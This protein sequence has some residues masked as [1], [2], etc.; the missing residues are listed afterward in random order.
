M[1]KIYVIG[2]GM[3]PWNVPEQVKSLIY[4]SDL[5]V[6][7]RRLLGYFKDYSGDTA[8]IEGSLDTIIEQIHLESSR[9]KKVVVLADGDPLFFGI[10]KKLLEMLDPKRIEIIPN[11]TTLQAAA[12]RAK[13]PWDQVEIVSLHGRND[14]WPLL[15]ALAFR[16]I[17][18][19]YTGNAKGPG[20]IA[21]L[22]KSRGIDTF[23]M[24]VLEDLFQE[25]EKVTEL[26]FDRA[27]EM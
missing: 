24:I 10:G 21:S 11:I 13:I 12:S 6:G 8:T 15:R 22:M 9:G 27:G 2:V 17:V 7:G 18:G 14:V 23:R 20:F 16:D 1:E 4:E 5:L 25:T 3:A 26:P 19:V